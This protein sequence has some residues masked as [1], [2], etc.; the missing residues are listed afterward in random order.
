MIIIQIHQSEYTGY[1]V[2]ASMRGVNINKRKLV[3]NFCLFI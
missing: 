3:F 2:R 1:R